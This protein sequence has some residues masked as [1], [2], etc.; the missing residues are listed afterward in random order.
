MSKIILRGRKITGGTAEGEALVTKESL[1]GFGCFDFDT[2][3]VIDYGHEWYGQNVSGKVLVFK[4]AKG[5][6]AW[7]IAHQTLRL[8]GKSP[9]AYVTKE[10]NP[11]T[12][13]GAVVARI[14]AVTE[15]DQDPTEVIA[16]GDWVRVD[17]DQGFIEITKK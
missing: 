13:L 8:V 3:T 17:A 10:S 4:T 1:G 11:Q 5:S 15:F 6:S 7:S 16:T 14:P 2:G 12:A 9:K